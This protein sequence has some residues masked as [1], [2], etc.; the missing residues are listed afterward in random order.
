MHKNNISGL[1]W[2][3]LVAQSVILVLSF[4]SIL[5]LIGISTDSSQSIY[6]I[7]SYLTGNGVFADFYGN[8]N[9][10]KELPNKDSAYFLSPLMI[11]LSRAGKNLPI[12]AHIIFLIVSIF[13]WVKGC[14][15]LGI[16]YL[17]AVTIVLTYPFIFSLSR[18]NPILLST[19]LFFLAYSYAFGRNENENKAIFLAALS[20]S[21][22]PT[23][24]ILLFGLPFRMILRKSYILVGFT[25]FNLILIGF[26]SHSSFIDAINRYNLSFELYQKSYIFG[27]GGTLFNNSLFGL[28][29]IILLN[30][31]NDINSFYYYLP[32][33]IKYY[34]TISTILLLVIFVI[35]FNNFWVKNILF[36]TV[37]AVL[38]PPISADYKLL[39]LVISL[40]F[41]L[42]AGNISII[43]RDKY[44]YLTIFFL[45][46]TIMPKHLIFYRT[47]VEIG[48]YY[49]LQSVVN[50]IQMCVLL[51]IINKLNYE[52]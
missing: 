18:S 23:S 6:P 41:L 25:I 2:A 19:G 40:I 39:Y 4:I 21:V 36:I 34:S 22:H 30:M 42:H 20:V 16:G 48:E 37:L 8:L 12:I 45:L 31:T 13:T 7:S 9:L 17:V 5:E 28:L 50:P 35:L 24:L 3:F 1:M 32:K 46:L 52:K 11:Y 15:N 33:L 51:Y 49:T 26:I 44:Y 27:M 38:I 10:S 43:I 47:Y 14:R 29:K